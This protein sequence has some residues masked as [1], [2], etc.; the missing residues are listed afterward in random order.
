MPNAFP[1]RVCVCNIPNTFLFS[2]V[3]KVQQFIISR[4]FSLVPQEPIWNDFS[5]TLH[6][7]N[8]RT[9]MVVLCYLPFYFY[10]L[11]AASF[12]FA[13]IFSFCF[14]SSYNFFLIIA[15]VLP[16]FIIKGFKIWFRAFEAFLHLTLF[17][18]LQSLCACTLYVC[19]HVW[20]ACLLQ[21]FN[22]LKLC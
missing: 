18:R 11:F 2:T 12:K 16:R 1:L 15:T 17:K 13:S 5:A 20:C 10:L 19:V 3:C 6:S 14:F 22:V 8:F 9:L 7:I 21:V 4:D